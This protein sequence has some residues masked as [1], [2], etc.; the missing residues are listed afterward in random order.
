MALLW[1]WCWAMLLMALMRGHQAVSSSG[2]GSYS[3][4][5]EDQEVVGGVAEGG[6]GGLSA[7]LGAE[8]VPVVPPPEGGGGG[9]SGGGGGGPQTGARTVEEE[10]RRGPLRLSKAV[11][12]GCAPEFERVKT[13]GRNSTRTRDRSPRWRRPAADAAASSQAT[14]WL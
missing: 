1:A 12:A 8:E 10:A 14:A 4:V 5:E 7:F 11:G 3:P 13:A 2:S 6:G 9:G